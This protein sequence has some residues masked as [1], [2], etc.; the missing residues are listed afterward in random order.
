MRF[1]SFLVVF[2]VCST[3]I[4]AQETRTYYVGNNGDPADAFP[5]PVCAGDW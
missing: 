1:V 3:K 4:L 2:V 5:L